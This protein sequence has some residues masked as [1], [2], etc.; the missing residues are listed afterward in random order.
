M[1]A[2]T[3]GVLFLLLIILTF[4][5][6]KIFEKGGVYCRCFSILCFPCTGNCLNLD[7]QMS[8]IQ[9][10]QTNPLC[11]KDDNIPETMQIESP[12]AS[13]KVKKPYVEIYFYPN[14]KKASLNRKSSIEEGMEL[15]VVSNK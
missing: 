4:C 9:A 8:P 3:T 2:I 12:N 15:H 11:A 14:R 13:E 10:Q 6:E 5:T 7:S 1:F